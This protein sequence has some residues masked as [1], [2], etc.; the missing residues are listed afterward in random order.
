[1]STAEANTKPTFAQAFI[2][3]HPAVVVVA[4][5]VALALHLLVDVALAGQS[6]TTS[7]PAPAALSISSTGPILRCRRGVQ[8]GSVDKFLLPALF[9]TK[10]RL[11][12][13][14]P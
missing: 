12:L 1:M 6:M 13:S 9:G 10:A 8:N 7:H 3:I 2:H 5:I 11:Y 4:C 14:N